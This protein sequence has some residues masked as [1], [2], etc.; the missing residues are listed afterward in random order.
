M[1]GYVENDQRGAYTYWVSGVG[2][3]GCRTESPDMTYGRPPG[4]YRP[5]SP[6]WT[7][8]RH[9]YEPVFVSP[10]YGGLCRGSAPEVTN[11]LLL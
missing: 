3:L 4:F 11:R 7:W 8:G 5:V 10:W 1:S 9:V 6:S 2:V